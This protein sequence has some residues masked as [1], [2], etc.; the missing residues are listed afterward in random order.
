[1]EFDLDASFQSIFRSVE[2]DYHINYSADYSDVKVQLAPAAVMSG[3]VKYMIDAERKASGPL[4]ERDADF[5]VDGTLEFV[6]A[7]HAMLT[8]D[9]MFKYSVDATSGA[10]TKM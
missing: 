1:G 6:S 4:H 9:G 2:R 3:S 8:L 10:V 7:G 5:H